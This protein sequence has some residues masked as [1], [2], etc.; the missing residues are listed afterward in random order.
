MKTR[1]LYKLTEANWE[2]GHEHTKLKWGPGVT[3]K[4][5]EPKPEAPLCTEHWIH[6]YQHPLLAELMREAHVSFKDPVLWGCR[7]AGNFK[8]TGDK[9]GVTK[10]TTIR[11]VKL[12]E[13]TTLQR[14]RF[15]ILCAKEVYEGPSWVA[16]ADGWLSGK[17]RSY[18]AAY[19]AY[20]STFASTYAHAATAS[21][22][23]YA[24]T[25][26]DAAT[27]AYAA[28]AAL[29]VKPID[30]VA[31]AKRAIKEEKA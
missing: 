9:C 24:A 25:Y 21:Y 10:L 15:A 20:D 12:P 8:T 7:A 27:A 1:T 23:A 19:A 3:H 30:L 31:T 18:N 26:A 13:I 6:A 4:I 14:S 22:A 5:E 17:D 28:A 11:R 29:K 16:W 2:T